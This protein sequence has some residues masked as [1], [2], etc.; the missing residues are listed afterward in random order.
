MYD[1]PYSLGRQCVV[2]YV[3][4]LAFIMDSSLNVIDVCFDGVTLCCITFFW[5]ILLVVRCMSLDGT[6]YV[7]L[8][9]L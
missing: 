9:S 7:K 6:V 1:L 4:V 3:S 8:V 2:K 5:F